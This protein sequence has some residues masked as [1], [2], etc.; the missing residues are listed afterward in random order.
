MITKIWFHRT[1]E[2]IPAITL[3]TEG[4]DGAFSDIFELTEECYDIWVPDTNHFPGENLNEGVVYD[5]P[6]IPNLRAST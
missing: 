5:K 1:A 6:L 4:P 3:F 2:N